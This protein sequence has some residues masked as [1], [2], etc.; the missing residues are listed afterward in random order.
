[1]SGVGRPK[2]GVAPVR[3]SHGATSV[4]EQL[5]GSAIE[6]MPD[7]LGG[8]CSSSEEDTEAIPRH[9]P[10]SPAIVAPSPV[11]TADVGQ[12]EAVLAEQ[13]LAARPSS[14]P[15]PARPLAEEIR[16][17]GP[18]PHDMVETSAQGARQAAQP[19]VFTVFARF[20]SLRIVPSANTVYLLLCR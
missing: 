13:A 8:L 19:F 11:P 12:P 14:S 4:G 10:S 16:P 1:M 7:V 15:P 5:E 6:P 17:F 20:I 18:S 3:S 2:T 9:A